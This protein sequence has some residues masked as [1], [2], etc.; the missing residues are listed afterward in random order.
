M[1]NKYQSRMIVIAAHTPPAMAAWPADGGESPPPLRM[2][3]SI[4]N[5][6]VAWPAGGLQLMMTLNR[7]FRLPLLNQL[8]VIPLTAEARTW[9]EAV[10]SNRD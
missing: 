2:T 9:L 7:K 10:I 3:G 1:V 8:D 6:G 4:D 5:G